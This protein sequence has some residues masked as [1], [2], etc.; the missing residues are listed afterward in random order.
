MKSVDFLINS[1]E[2]LHKQFSNCNKRYE[3]I[4]NPNTHLVEVTPVEFC[5][6]NDEYINEELIFEE[7][8][9]KSFS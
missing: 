9:K 7:E 2:K 8:L 3:H 1:L 5:N 4:N 6:D